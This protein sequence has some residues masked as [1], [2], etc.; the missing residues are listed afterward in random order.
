MIKIVCCTRLRIPSADI[1]IKPGGYGGL[2]RAKGGDITA[3]EQQ[4]EAKTR[5]GGLQVEEA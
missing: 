3:K 4:A 2:G 5:A 1:T